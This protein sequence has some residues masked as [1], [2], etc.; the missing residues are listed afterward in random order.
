MPTNTSPYSIGDAARLTFTVTST[1]GVATNTAV[2]LIVN[3]P[4]G[5]ATVAAA[6]PSTA[7]A[8]GIA[9][10]ATGVWT[11]DYQSTEAGR[12]T[13]RWESTGSVKQSTEGAWAVYPRK[14]SS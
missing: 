9:H 2:R 12:Y 4:S 1:A 5:G 11:Y 8:Q 14:A 6:G 7:G 13:Y 10:S 3:T